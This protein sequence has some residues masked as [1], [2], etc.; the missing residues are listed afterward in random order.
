VRQIAKLKTLLA[1]RKE[2]PGQLS[3]GNAELVVESKLPVTG[4]KMKCAE[5]GTST[6]EQDSRQAAPI[7]KE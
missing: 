7:V 2:T 6:S 3:V 1:K 4:M 5:G